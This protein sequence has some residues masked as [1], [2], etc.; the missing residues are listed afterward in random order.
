MSLKELA[1]NHVARLNALIAECNQAIEKL[2]TQKN[3]FEQEKATWE[4]ALNGES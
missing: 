4:A 1:D 3:A 2:Q